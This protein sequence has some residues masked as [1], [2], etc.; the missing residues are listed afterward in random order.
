MKGG[1]YN[2]GDVVT[3]PETDGLKGVIVDVQIDMEYFKD[4]NCDKDLDIRDYMRYQI[5]YESE[6]LGVVDVF[7]NE[8]EL[9]E[10]N[11]IGEETDEN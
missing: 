5:H 3:I 7:Y 10:C 2:I 9:D 4:E 8:Y 1:K 6:E 11:D